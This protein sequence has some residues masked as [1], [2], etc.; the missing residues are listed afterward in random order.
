MDDSEQPKEVLN[1]L[2]DPDPT[3]VV[4]EVHGDDDSENEE[5]LEVNHP[6]R[7]SVFDRIETD[8]RLKFQASD[9]N[10][11][12][13]VGTGESN[14]LSFYPLANK[15][16]SCIRIPKELATEVMKTHR[17]TLFGYFLGPRLN[18]PVVERFVKQAWGKF[19]FVEAMMNNN[20]IYFFKFNDFGGSNQ[21]VEAGPLMIRGVPL[22]V[23]HWDPVK[24]LSKPIHNTCP[25]WVKLHN[26]P[27]VAFNK[28]GIS[29]IAS[30]LGVPKQMDACTASMCDK[31]WGRPGFAKVLIDTWAVGDLKRELQVVIPSLT[32]SEDVR[33]A[34]KV[35]YL[36]EPTQCSHCLVFGHKTNTCVK[37]VIEQNKKGKNL[38]VDSDGFTKVQRK[39]WRPKNTGSTSGTKDLSKGCDNIL[40]SVGDGMVDI[41]SEDRPVIEENMVNATTSGLD[42]L[43]PKDGAME[44]GIAN[45]EKGVEKPENRVEQA[46][47]MDG[48]KQTNAVAPSRRPDKQPVVAPIVKPVVNH[49]SAPLEVPLK[50][51]LK[52]TNRFSPLADPKKADSGLERKRPGTPMTR[53][54][55]S[56]PQYLHAFIRLRGQQD[57]FFITFVYGANQL[58][59]RKQLWSNLRKAK[60]L[61]GAQPWAIMGD[62]NA[63]LFPHDGFGGISRRN[64]SMEDF[65]NCVEDIEVI[66]VTYT[67]VQYTWTQ[68]PQG[69]DGLH[70]KLDRIMANTDFLSKFAGSIASF[71][72]RGLSDH[73]V[74]I[75]EI[76][77]TKRKRTKGFKFDN[78]V[79]DNAEFLGVVAREWKEP[80]FG[81]FMHQLLLHLKR[82]KRPLRGL[83][84]RCG[85]ISKRVVDL[86][87][88]M[89]I[90]QLA[91][92]VHPSDRELM[93]DLAHIS[94][95]YQNALFEEDS[96]FRQR[97]KVAWIK[98]ADRNTKFFHNVVKER[99]SRNM[100]KSVAGPDGNFV[101]D[102]AVAPLFVDHF[103]SFLGL[104]DPLVVPDMP[105]HLFQNTLSLADS[106]EMIRSISDKEIKDALFQIGNDKAPGSDGFSSK[107]FKAAWPIVGKDV[108]IAVHNFFYSGRLT[109]EINHTLL[110]FIPKIPNATR[111]SDFRPISCCTVLY[112]IISKIICDRIKPYLG[113]IVSP[114][115]SAFIPGRR[116][117]DNILMAHELV[118]GYQKDAG[119]PRCAFKIDLRKAYD[120]VDW[121]FLL[122]MM[123]GFGF[124]PVLCRWIDEM[125]ST[126]SF[127]IALNG[128]T[129]GFFKGARGLRQGDPISP[130]LFTLVMEGFS[131]LLRL[132]IQEATN[133]QYHQECED[134]QITHL[135]FADDLFVFTGANLESVE[136]L[137]KALDMFRT[138]SGLEPNL[139]KSEVFFCNVPLNDRQ[140]ILNSLPL[141]AGS[142]PIRYLGVPLSS[143][144]LRVG[145]FQ[146]LVTR[147][148]DRIH[149]WKSKFLSFAGRKQLVVSVL[150]SMQLYWMM[151]YVLPSAVVHELEGLFRDFLWA[152]GDSSRGRCK[153]A[154]EV[155]CKPVLCGGLGFKRLSAWNRTL[156]TKH[157]WDLLSKRR[158]LWVD[159]IWRYRMH[160]GSFWSIS[161]RPSWSWTFRKI[162]SIRPMVRQFFSFQLGRGD[163]VNAWED[164][165]VG[166]RP[167]SSMISFRRF[168]RAGF[169]TN[170]QARDVVLTLN[171]IWPQEWLA[172]N[173]GAFS[174]QVPLLD[175]NQ[176]DV[177]TWR[178]A[179]YFSVKQAWRD[180]DGFHQPAR[181][182]KVKNEVDLWGFPDAWN[183]ILVNLEDNRGPKTLMQKLALSASI[184]FIWRE[185][186]RRLFRD[187]KQPSVGTFKMI[188]GS[189]IESMALRRIAAR[190]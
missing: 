158:T 43:E 114:T 75:L 15:V 14:A 60:V 119:K 155:V 29:R 174:N 57:G 109:K 120:T 21:V 189:I 132:C 13:A 51:I 73:A 22:F 138:R 27:L 167:L 4:T 5:Q 170:S 126:S 173:P 162:L 115:Q 142:F 144:C 108:Q 140:V 20:G 40:N 93:E 134:M 25:L 100:V 89:D 149:N 31:S 107:F 64:A 82:L 80:V 61:L 105:D 184:Y 44:S 175:D 41:G 92:D 24:G 79:A 163:Q 166:C 112:K 128:E 45:K 111:V 137:K 123:K 9:L 187:L 34:I 104:Q 39:E 52:N 8:A 168:A 153:V 176:D 58:S 117:S 179:N 130:Y 143:T 152:Q 26:I 50:T 68:K 154:W 65:F 165:W 49:F 63:M 66:D 131:M 145:D 171:G 71:N 6:S 156:L 53:G 178:G 55:D 74:G 19:G 185:R 121:R 124:H 86:K 2:G 91:C 23:E 118:A 17:S 151:V 103:K 62:F 88:E 54:P 18:F 125:L 99:R 157:I 122:R 127:S 94:L 38:V 95:A 177:I 32:S 1:M 102:D 37:A 85:D 147:A 181:W 76:K 146:P 96:Y 46:S 129:E 10:F 148:R 190:S 98:G 42:V 135:C 67:G 87:A 30:A 56:N 161:T 101:Y 12:K 188:R 36:W 186:N 90:I 16:H 183:D 141:V 81:S 28:E 159:W 116:I 164:S 97:A 77:G 139:S 106:L 133:F 113:G 78:F 150:Q 72:P 180:L 59:E 182:T 84:G 69:G 172:S 110:C 83:R 160:A 11:A 35:E 47:R 48:H 7:A 33:V 70:R 3:M 169:N 136:V